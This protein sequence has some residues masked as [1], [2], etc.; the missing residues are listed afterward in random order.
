MIVGRL[1]PAGTGAYINQ[2]QKL[3]ADRDQIAISAQQEAE[4]LAHS[5]AGEGEI[6]AEQNDETI[7]ENKAANG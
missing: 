7:S 3:A 4:A 2:I 5:E 6:L 1:I